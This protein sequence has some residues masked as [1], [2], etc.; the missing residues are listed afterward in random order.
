MNEAKK[1][2]LCGGNQQEPY[3]SKIYYYQGQD[4][5]LVK[6]PNCGLVF[7][8]PRP[9]LATIKNFYDEKYF[10]SDFAC[11]M[12]EGD[13]LAAEEKRAQEYQSLL[14]LIKKYKSRGKLLEIGCAGGSFLALARKEGFEV[15]GVDIS[16]WAVS[17]AKNKYQLEVQ[18]GRLLELNLKPESYEVI[19]FADLLEHEP[20]P[21]K[22]LKKVFSLLK[23]AGLVMLKVPTYVNSIYYQIIKLLPWNLVSDKLDPRLLIALKVNASNLSKFPPYHLFEF[24]PSTLKAIIRKSG[25]HLVELKNT[26]IIPEFLKKK[27]AGLIARGLGLGFVSLKWLM[28]HFSLPGGHIIALAVKD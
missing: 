28:E 11:G 18:K 22:F 12:I 16:E 5:D 24:S 9:D 4:Y 8:Q 26:L 14:G 2:E 10:E 21:M 20:E 1:C 17:Q 13:Y 27:N 15:E 19:F 3:I 7:V 6:C 25:F 23:P